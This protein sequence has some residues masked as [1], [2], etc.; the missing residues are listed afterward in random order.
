[1]AHEFS[2][3]DAVMVWMGK[4][5][6]PAVGGIP[7]G[8]RVRPDVAEYLGPPVTRDGVWIDMCSM[9]QHLPQCYRVGELAPLDAEVAVR[10]GLC[11]DCLGYGTTDELRDLVAHST[12]IAKPCGNCGGSGRPSLRVEVEQPAPGTT[13]GKLLPQPHAPVLVAEQD[14]C[15]ACG[16][17]PGQEPPGWDNH[18][19]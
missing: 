6:P 9:G 16:T 17:V 18:T 7:V 5:I 19:A 4:G 8:A 10:H 12:E 13:L 2:A 1:M 14:Y 11:P 3:G 15:L